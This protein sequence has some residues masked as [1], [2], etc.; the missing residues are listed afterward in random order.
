MFQ[1]N[2][3]DVPGSRREFWRAKKSTSERMDVV[4]FGGKSRK[5][6]T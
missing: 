3:Q 5:V 2:G 6:R 4:H 1:T